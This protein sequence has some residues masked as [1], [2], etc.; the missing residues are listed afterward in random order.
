MRSLREPHGFIGTVAVGMLLFAGAFRVGKAI[1]RRVRAVSLS[2]AGG[3]GTITIRAATQGDGGVAG[4][5]SWQ[6]HAYALVRRAPRAAAA[7]AAPA[8]K[9]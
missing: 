3:G 8:A 7:V 4:R 9:E 2:V 6:G 5:G 1:N